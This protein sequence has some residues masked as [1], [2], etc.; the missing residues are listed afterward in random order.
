MKDVPNMGTP[1]DRDLRALS[2]RIDDSDRRARVDSA[3]KLIYGPRRLNVNSK[4]VNTELDHL[5]LV[6]TDVSIH[7]PFLR[8]IGRLT[9]HSRMH[10][11]DVYRA[12]TLIST[13]S[14]RLMCCI[15]LLML[16]RRLVKSAACAGAP[17]CKSFLVGSARFRC[18]HRMFASRSTLITILIDC[19]VYQKY[20]LRPHPAVQSC[21][22][23]HASQSVTLCCSREQETVTC[24]SGLTIRP[25]KLSKI[26]YQDVDG[27][28]KPIADL[29][30]LCKHIPVHVIFGQR[31]DSVYAFP[32]FSDSNSLLNDRF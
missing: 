20:G 29:D 3:R 26:M 18:L 8:S 14:Y 9:D 22:V 28:T 7:L 4:A 6:P 15:V 10:S 24:F 19:F 13:I 32:N 11:L 1:D 31:N 27:P 16:L 12:L 30:I 5:S 17:S 25:F 23:P 21:K 2:G